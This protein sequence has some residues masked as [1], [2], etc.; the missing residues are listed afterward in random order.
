M[1]GEEK[2][3]IWNIEDKKNSSQIEEEIKKKESQKLNLK[4]I[5][6]IELKQSIKIEDN[7][8]NENIEESK[9]F[10]IYDPADNN[11]DLN[12]WSSTAGEEINA[13]LKRLE[14][15]KLSKTANQILERILLSFSYAPKGMSTDEFVN[16]RINWLIKNQ[17]SDLIESFLKQNK[18]FKG[19][20]RAVQYLVDENIANSD[21]TEGC[22]KIRFI[23]SKIKDAYLEK[24]KIYCLVFNN[25]KAEAQLL[26][27]LLRE[28]KQSDKFYDD[29][30]NFL[31][32]VSDKTI[33]KIN[34]NN[35]LNF[36]LSSITIKDFNFKPNKNTK[37]EIWKYLNTSNLIKLEDAS[38]KKRL[39]ELELAAKQGQID[40]ITIFKIYE[41]IPFT[42]NQ[43]ID[44]KNIYQTLEVSDARPLIYQ[45]YLLSEDNDSKINY[46]FLLEELFKKENLTNIY[47]DFLSNEIKKIGIENISE[48]YQE[49]ANNRIISDN[50]FL[51]Q[52]VKYN[53]KV[54]HQ[55]KITK[56]Y[57]EDENKKKVQK[58]IDKIFKKISKNRKYF[59]SA[60]DLALVDS[61][62]N[63]GFNLP[64][65][66]DYKKLSKK[67]DIPRNLLKLI[68]NNQNA[69][70]A[71]KIVE[72]IGEDEPQ[73]LDPETIY[74]IINLLNKMNLRQIRNIVFNSALP[75]RA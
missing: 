75:L 12:M 34:E 9:I 32:G 62:I 43:L 68:E 4:S 39:K 54:L 23:D 27:D 21:I 42:L 66:F 18:E 74:F 71:L 45:K 64:S 15:I 60:K 17:R 72:I 59:Y 22:K 52:K 44:A 19:K 61:L 33:V 11:F 7:T 16:L 28:Q 26:L 73:Q 47:S 8:L 40:K 13:S 5:K 65:N 46:L 6:D 30:I 25:K 70:L 55:S 10:G 35:L 14:K 53:D 51:S 38:D 56:Y 2:I 1:K 29:K 37:E 20:S 31:L 3:D 57:L 69:F 67:Y 36:Y 41:Q 50:N 24:F 63:D 49:T 48:R 58:D